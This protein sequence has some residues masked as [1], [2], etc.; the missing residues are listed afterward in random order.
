M[1]PIIGMFTEINNQKDTKVQYQYAKAIEACGGLPVLFPYTEKMETLD[2]FI[3]ICD[4]FC[5]TGGADIDPKRYGEEKKATCGEVMYYRDEVEFTAFQK[6]MIFPILY[7][8][9]KSPFK[10]GVIIR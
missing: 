1:Q 4:G 10:K 9:S 6:V 3:K 8:K 5:F 7:L 2:A